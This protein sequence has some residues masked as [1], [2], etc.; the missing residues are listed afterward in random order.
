MIQLI[1]SKRRTISLTI[2]DDGELLV[3][4]P[5]GTRIE[6]INKFLQEKDDWISKHKKLMKDFLKRRRSH[7]FVTKDGFLFLGKRVKPSGI[8][9][10]DRDSIEVYLKEK[11]LNVIEKRTID[12]CNEFGL[13]YSVLRISNAKRRWG[14]CGSKN[15]LNFTWRLMMAPSKVIDYVIIHEISHIK[16]KNHSARF[17][18]LV[19]SMMLDYKKHDNWLEE[20]RFLLD[21]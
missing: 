14:S 19:E 17:W 11:A 7:K 10:R 1:R 16:H 13:E 21:L 4:A 2:K 9:L 3:K 20:N 6:Y 18:S 12:Y 5:N 15:S 8:N